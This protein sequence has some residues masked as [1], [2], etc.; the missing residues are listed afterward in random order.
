MYSPNKTALLNLLLNGEN[1]G[2][3]EHQIQPDSRYSGIFL[4]SKEENVVTKGHVN[5]S[6][7][8]VMRGS[9][10]QILMFFKPDL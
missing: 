2:P 9:K 4:C 7:H 1:P 3:C 5:L 6:I 10:E 8:H